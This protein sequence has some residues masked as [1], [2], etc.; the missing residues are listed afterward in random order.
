MG[1]GFKQLYKTSKNGDPQINSKAPFWEYVIQRE[2]QQSLFLF[3]FIYKTIKINLL[4][5][6]FI[7]K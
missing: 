3:Y 5:F 2:Y 4:S 1:R 7:Y 6:Y